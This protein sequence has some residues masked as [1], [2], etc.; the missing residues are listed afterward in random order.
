MTQLQQADE[1]VGRVP[2]GEDT[3]DGSLTLPAGR[4]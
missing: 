2:V 3:L 1:R 4:S